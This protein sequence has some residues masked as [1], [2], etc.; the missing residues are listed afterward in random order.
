MN[1]HIYMNIYVYIYIYRIVWPPEAASWA[2]PTPLID[3]P[4]FLP[5]SFQV[6]GEPLFAKSGGVFFFVFTTLEPRVEL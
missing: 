3:A 6:C 2:H 4:L 5:P 1:T